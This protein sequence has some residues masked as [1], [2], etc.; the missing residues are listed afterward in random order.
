MRPRLLAALAGAISIVSA[1]SARAQLEPLDLAPLASID[2]SRWSTLTFGFSELEVG[3][4]AVR[5]GDP[6]TAWM[7]PGV[8][9]ETTTITFDWSSRGPIDPFAVRSIRVD[10]SPA[11]APIAVAVGPDLATLEDTPAEVARDATGATLTLRAP[12]LRVLA[13]RLP[14]GVSVANVKIL[15]GPTNGTLGDVTATCD[16]DGV[17][18][19]LDAAGVLGVEAVRSLPS[20]GAL[21]LRQRR[22]EGA[23]LT[24]ASVRFDPRPSTYTYLV[25]GIG[26]AGAPAKVSVTCDGAARARP[27]PGPIHGVIEGFYGRPWTWPERA[28]IVTAMGALG[29]DTYIYAPKNDPL[30]RDRW[31]DPYDAATLDEFRDL[32]TIGRGTGVNVVWAVSPGLDI[33]PS[34]PSD[35]AALT[36]KVAT[37]AE[38]AGIRDAALLMD[39]IS[40]AHD[41]ALGAAHAELAQTLLDSM[42]ARDPQSRLW[43]V[44][45]VYAGLAGSFDAGDAAYLAAL[46]AVPA[47]V[48]IAW[49]GPGVFAKTIDVA[50]A[51]AFGA[52]FGRGAEGVWIWDNY[53]VNDVAVFRR[54][55]ARP[56]TGRE[57]LL[58]GSGGLLSNPM[59]HGLASLPAIASYA[60]LALDP[61]SYA[62]SRSAGEPLASARLALVLAD[63]DG[64][65]RALEDLFA[66]LVHHDTLWSNDFA[67]PGLTAALSAYAAAPSPGPARRAAA[68]DLATRLARL[69]IA[70]VDLRRDLDDPSLADEIDA[71]ARATSVSARTALAALGAARADLAGDA[72][73][74]ALAAQEA[75]CLWAAANQPSW[76]TIQDAI[77]DL[78]PFADTSLC[79]ADDLFVAP[80]PVTT[81]RGERWSYTLKD[82]IPEA[83]ATWSLV[84]SGGASA[85]ISSEGVVTWTPA[86]LGRFRLVALRSGEAGASAAVIDVVVTEPKAKTPAESGGC[87]CRAAGAP[88]DAPVAG[89][90]ALA[91]LA[92]RRRR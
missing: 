62:A 1:P 63:A 77:E 42:K 41:A 13:L 20:G 89:W 91:A 85:S 72:E 83:G 47:E 60:E 2:V 35:V 21:R 59:R 67:S 9:G 88:M 32:A 82:R 78:V 55:Y 56:I 86:R 79:S 90:L 27:A 24:D 64:Y 10:V 31:R 34:S 49:T 68:L 5:D 84:D 48:S 4:A 14:A 7:V 19:A 92:R 39:D 73:A 58:P 15:G 65:P 38:E 70:D 46:A 40:A 51:A 66:E 18:L 61:P 75:A 8:E 74:S 33:D 81:P 80:E 22:A 17:H 3:P 52:T 6:K 37:L 16:G 87:G 53:P 29:M 30:H 36:G 50:D 26:A 76:R 12:R 11:D 71:H 57:S 54:M 69:V 23:T 25:H 43:F 44:P 28:K 45:T